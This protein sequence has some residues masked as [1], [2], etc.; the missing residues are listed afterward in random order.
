MVLLGLWFLPVISIISL[1][2]HIILINGKII[3]FNLVEF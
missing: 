2:I 3:F 1:M